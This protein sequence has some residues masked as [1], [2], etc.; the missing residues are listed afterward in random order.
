MTLAEVSFILVQ[1]SWHKLRSFLL[2]PS[3]DRL[4]ADQ[5]L[6]AVQGIVMKGHTLPQALERGFRELS[7]QVPFQ[8]SPGAFAVI[9]DYE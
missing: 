8:R 3:G 9:V 1:S 5:V 4:P 6:V 2:A 7:P